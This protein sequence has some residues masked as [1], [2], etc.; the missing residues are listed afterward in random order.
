MVIL[1]C[2]PSGGVFEAGLRVL[3]VRLSFGNRLM[4]KNDVALER[5]GAA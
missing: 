3:A 1:R 4:S 2:I 5:E